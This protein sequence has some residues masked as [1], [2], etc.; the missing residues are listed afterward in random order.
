MKVKI[1]RLELGGGAQVIYH[2]VSAKDGTL[3]WGSRGWASEKGPREM[4]KRLGAE[5]VD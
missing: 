2:L 3:L 4:A 5:I 1:E